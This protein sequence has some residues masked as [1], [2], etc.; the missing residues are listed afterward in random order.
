MCH[1]CECVGPFRSTYPYLPVK[2]GTYSKY[3][4]GEEDEIL[5]LLVGPLLLLGTLGILTPTVTR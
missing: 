3:N 2:T 5:R 1:E 4:L